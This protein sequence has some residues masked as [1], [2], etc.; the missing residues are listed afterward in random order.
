MFDSTQSAHLSSLQV[1]FEVKTTD[2]STYWHEI[3]HTKLVKNQAVILAEAS[4]DAGGISRLL[5]AYGSMNHDVLAYHDAS[6]LADWAARVKFVNAIDVNAHGVFHG[7]NTGDGAEL[8]TYLDYSSNQAGNLG[9][10]LPPFNTG[11]WPP[12]GFIHLQSCEV[13]ANS[14]WIATL[15]PQANEYN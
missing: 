14:Y 9:S 7:H 12:H 3:D 2:S 4:L 1:K 8:V 15:Y 10:G 5:G 6:S 11:K 13:G